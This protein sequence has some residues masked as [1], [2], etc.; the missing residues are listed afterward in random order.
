MK[1]RVTANEPDSVAENRAS[2]AG[3]F[4]KRGKEQEI[5]GRPEGWKHKWISAHERQQ[6]K[7]SNYDE[8]IYKHIN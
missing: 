4:G 6:G 8:A 1:R 3:S 5:G 2:R 7:N